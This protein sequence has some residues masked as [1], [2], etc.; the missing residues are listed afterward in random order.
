[1]PRE[2]SRSISDTRWSSSFAW[3]SVSGILAGSAERLSHNSSIRS[4]RSSGLNLLMSMSSLA[5]TRVWHFPQ[6]RSSVLRS[7]NSINAIRRKPGNVGLVDGAH[8]TGTARV[9]ISAA[10]TVISAAKKRVA[11]AEMIASALEKS[12]CV[13]EIIV[14]TTDIIASCL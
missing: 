13:V 2:S 4:S 12:V 14:S 6:R 1:M 11:K 3:A 8:P 9:V 10:D 5:I 7:L